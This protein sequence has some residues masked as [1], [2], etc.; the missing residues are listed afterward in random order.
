M[1]K[2]PTEDDDAICEGDS[3]VM[4]AMRRANGSLPAREWFDNLDKSGKAKLL[5][6]FKILENSLEA[7][8]PRG[9]L[10]EKVATSVQGLWELRVTPKGGTAP[11]LR[12]LYVRVARTLWAASGFTKQK[13][14]LEAKDVQ[15]GDRITM[16]WEEENK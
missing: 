5:A 11:H 1:T 7:K 12:L 14:K 3:F 6:R 9:D 13:N 2:V 16:E 15:L 4:R 10:A 8:R